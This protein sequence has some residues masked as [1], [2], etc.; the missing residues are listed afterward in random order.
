M[1]VE[2]AEQLHKGLGHFSNLFEQIP[3]ERHGLENS[4]IVRHRL[5]V[6][7]ILTGDENTSWHIDYKLTPDNICY[8]PVGKYTK[9]ADKHLHY[10]RLKV[11]ER[12]KKNQ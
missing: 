8:S 2:F 4:N 11:A 5:R 1:R 12:Y 3:V 7:S 6:K 10:H 9:V